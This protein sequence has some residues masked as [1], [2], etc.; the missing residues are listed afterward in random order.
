MRPTSLNTAELAQKL[1]RLAEQARPHAGRPDQACEQL[2][3]G[4]GVHAVDRGLA[5][6]HR[7]FADA[8]GDHLALDQQRGEFG[9]DQ[10]FF[11]VAEIDGA[12]RQQ[13]DRDQV[14]QQDATGERR[15]A[16]VDAPSAAQ[17]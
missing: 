8:G 16:A 17:Q 11:V 12:E 2:A 7:H 4:I 15:V 14:Q 1:A 3:R 10:L 5:A 13:R 9:V 6:D